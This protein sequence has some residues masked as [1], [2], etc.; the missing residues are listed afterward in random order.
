MIAHE[1]SGE[2][3]HSAYAAAQLAERLLAN[4]TAEDIRVAERVLQSVLRCQEL[5]QDSPHYGAFRWELEQEVVEDFN[6]VEFVLF[7]LIP[8]TIE[9]Q[10]QL[11]AT[12]TRQLKASIKLGLENIAKI[13]VGLAYTN[14]ALKDI[15]N[16][17]LGGEFLQ[18]EALAKRGYEKLQQ[19]IAFTDQSGGAYEYNSIP[20]VAVALDVL[21]TLEQLVQDEDTQVR[22]KMMLARLAVSVGLHMHAPT[23]RWAG[24]HGRAYHKSVIGEDGWYILKESELETMRDW[25]ADGTLPAW[26]GSMFNRQVLPDQVVETTGKEDQVLAS[27]YKTDTYTFGVASRN[28]Y[29]QANRYIAWQSNVFNI[30]YTRPGASIPGSIYTRYILDDEWLGDFSAGIGRGSSALLPDVGHFQGVQDQE[31][32]IGLYVPRNLNALEH[33]R[34]A[35]AVVAVARWNDQTDQVW[36]DSTRVETL[37]ARVPQGA[38]VVMASGS[39]M[40]AIKPFTITNLGTQDQLYL[41]QMPDSTLVFQLY[42][43]RGPM[44]TFW[45]LAWPGTFYQGLPRCGF[46]AEVAGARDFASP[47]AFAQTVNSGQITDQA[48]AP[49]TYSGGNETRPWRVEYQRDGRSLGMAV[50]L[51]DWF[52]PAERWT[53]AGPIGWPMLRSR[54]AAENTEG[55]VEVNGVR[56]ET[57]PN[58]PA[59]LYVSPTQ[60]TV[61]AAY[62]GP[63][64]SPMRLHLPQGNVTLD[65]LESGLVVWQQG[66]VSVEAIG[67]RSP[68]EI[69]RG[70]LIHRNAKQQPTDEQ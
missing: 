1:S 8:L 11:S 69:S 23:G 5:D 39:V 70:T 10:E 17:C 7:S 36:I 14:I 2:T 4:G 43:Y 63:T 59:W 12:L 18:D 6:A 35:K 64:P 48:E 29:N 42:N 61:V 45:E 19:W 20:Y 51:F 3:F 9:Y 68:P 13:N 49:Y 41:D 56:L 31:R 67:L 33:H 52:R 15:T 60:D 24:P 50:D 21:S 46:Y 32:A 40:L 26:V 27:T 28:L 30:Q 54:Y 37:P 47:A 58:H 62:H 57:A 65:S 66:E 22:A 34:S 44:K 38:T 16:T 53:D 25:L 55:V